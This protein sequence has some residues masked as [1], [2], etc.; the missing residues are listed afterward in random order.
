M[1]YGERRIGLAISD[2]LGMIAQPLPTITRRRG[3]RPPVA[4]IAD[5]ARQREAAAI[6]VGLPLDEHGDES[7]WT[8][9]VRAFAEKL[10]ERASLPLHFVDERMTSARA[11]RAIR[12][13]GLSR[14][15]RERKDLVDAT[16]AVIIL[17]THLDTIARLDANPNH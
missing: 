6:V 11:E 8:A 9:E 12:E 17:Q 10:A 14:T 4:E 1:D 15:Q 16:A 7:A 13:S 2:P 3:K 5:I